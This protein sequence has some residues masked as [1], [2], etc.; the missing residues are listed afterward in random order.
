MPLAHRQRGTLRRVSRRFYRP[1][2]L[3]GGADDMAATGT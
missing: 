1:L 2:T 3:T